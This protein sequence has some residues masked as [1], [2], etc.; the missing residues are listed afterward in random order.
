M[1]NGEKIT[2]AVRNTMKK[3]AFQDARNISI[4]CGLGHGLASVTNSRS[5]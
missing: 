3:T 2:K 1:E 5:G 4:N